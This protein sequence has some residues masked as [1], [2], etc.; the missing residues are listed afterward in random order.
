MPF[1]E[2]FMRYQ[3]Q[4]G[5]LLLWVIVAGCARSPVG[6]LSESIQ[7]KQYQPVRLDSHDVVP[8]GLLLPSHST[9]VVNADW[10]ST[11]LSAL[12]PDSVQY[13]PISLH[14]TLS[15]ALTN[16]QVLRDLGGRVV[17]QPERIG[18]RF[19]PQLVESNAR[20]GLQAALSAFDAQLDASALWSRNN[21]GLKLPPFGSASTSIEQY[22]YQQ[23][24]A[25][26]QRLRSGTI[27]QLQQGLD[28]ERDDLG[29]PPNRFASAFT[30][31]VGAH[32]RHP[33]G[34]GGGQFFNEVAGPGAS[35]GF[36]NGVVIANSRVDLA[37]T[38]YQIALRDTLYNVAR[39]YWLLQ[40]AYQRQDAAKQRLEV[41]T[42]LHKVA[43][44]K[45]GSGIQDPDTIDIALE[46]KIAAELAY[47]EAFAGPPERLVSGILGP[48]GALIAGSELG[49]L[50]LERR[51]RFLLGMAA[52]SPTL[53][54]PMDRPSDVPLVVDWHSTLSVAMT[55]RPELARQ[56]KLIKQK[57]LELA[58]SKRTL[59][60]T[61]DLIAQMRIL[62]FGDDLFG[63]GNVEQGS[64]V[65]ELLDGD[66]KEWAAG[67]EVQWPY[68]NRI[69][70]TAVR[71]AQLQL[72]RESAVLENQRL[73]ISHE[74][75]SAVSEVERS[76]NAIRLNRL[77]L[78][79]AQKRLDSH[80]RKFE[81]GVEVTVEAAAELELARI[82]AQLLVNLAIMD[83]QVALISLG[84]ARGTMLND[85]HV[86]VL[87]QTV[88]YAPIAETLWEPSRSPVD[89]I[90]SSN[91]PSRE[92]NSQPVDP[93][94]ESKVTELEEAVKP[95]AFSEG[96][97]RL[98]T[99]EVR[100]LPPVPIE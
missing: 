80:A 15:L 2:F 86:G 5:L 69:G 68:A 70:R 20:S 8:A 11:P 90:P 56:E 44:Q 97:L 89:A 51:L 76:H 63:S 83:Y 61:V 41:A 18:T 23:R 93:A 99:A 65:N 53:L 12:S 32:I 35:P 16:S 52:N 39:N 42:H 29:T 84:L 66:L 78:Q 49:V 58:A 98:P 24:A 64:A 25:I 85:L 43:T 72:A 77:R 13:E 38:D 36:Y 62:G 59:L 30:P 88:Q 96:S 22:T 81:L 17:S 28:Y 46:H 91:L 21:R 7:A 87:N 95:V 92:A 75:A 55:R 31:F 100:L 14:Q 74:L 1:P 47:Q 82:D 27:L 94:G 48:N 3:R 54:R 4:I 60:P 73:Q 37:L 71:N 19:A 9:G 33:L 67:V 45:S 10:R 26:S 40:F 50:Q 34:L 79:N 6:G 57:Q